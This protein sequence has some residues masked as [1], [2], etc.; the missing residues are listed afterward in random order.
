[1]SS[2]RGVNFHWVVL[3]AD[4]LHILHFGLDKTVPAKKEKKATVFLLF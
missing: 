4:L 2:H 3:G 1:M